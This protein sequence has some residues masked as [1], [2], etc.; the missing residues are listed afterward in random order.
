MWECLVSNRT[1]FHNTAYCL[2]VNFC[3]DVHLFQK[4]SSLNKEWQLHLSVDIR[5]NVIDCYWRL[6]WFIKLV[7]VDSP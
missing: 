2:V 3:T 6:C 4:K 5:T 7:V 1:R